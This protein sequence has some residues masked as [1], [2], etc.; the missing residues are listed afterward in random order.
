MNT[1]IIDMGSG[2]ICRNNRDVIR[3]MIYQVA[4]HDKDKAKI[5]FKWQL[6]SNKT[7]NYLEPLN[8]IEFDY[9][10]KLAANLGY[11]TT[12]SVFDDESLEFLQK[13]YDVPFIK[14]A[15]NT[16]YYPLLWHVKDEIKRM[17]SIENGADIHGLYEMYNGMY[18][19][20]LCCV[21]EYPARMEKYEE[22]FSEGYL[23]N[24]ISDHTVGLAL[25]KKYMPS[26]YECHFTPKR[27]EGND[28]YGDGFC[29]TI[30]ELKEVI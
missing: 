9:A 24:G 21:P 26:I 15:C 12:A 20:V 28:I 4:E 13:H 27:G 17:V 6:F 14:I 3:D 8:H 1:V 30:E 19:D 18:I 29:K 11:Q 22:L 23:T 25:Y 7:I 10:Y 16:K 5:I 2:A